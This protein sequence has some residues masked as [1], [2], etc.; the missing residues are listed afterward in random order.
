M[1]HEHANT[2]TKLMMAYLPDGVQF[3]QSIE[4]NPKPVNSSV[5]EDLQRCVNHN[6]ADLNVSLEL[7]QD[8]LYDVIMC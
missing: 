2:L 5:A 3:V 7:C 4:C 8:L 6:I 1:L